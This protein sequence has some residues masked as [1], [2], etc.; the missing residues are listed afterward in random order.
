MCAVQCGAA[1][2]GAAGWQQQSGRT[3]AGLRA[4]AG[5]GGSVVMKRLA[6]SFLGWEKL[7]LGIVYD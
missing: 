6:W 5:E 7:G 3:G 1:R 4:Q 2:R